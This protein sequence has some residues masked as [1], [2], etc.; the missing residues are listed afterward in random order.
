MSGLRILFVVDAGPRVG[1]GHVMRSLTLACAL[2]SQG[3][4]CAF[5]GPPAVSA[6]LAAF[7]PGTTRVAAVSTEPND[8]AAAVVT[9]PFDAVVFDHYGLGAAEHRVISRG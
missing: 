1:G 2:E 8:L 6:L 5:I 4:A 3:A 7:S 9:E